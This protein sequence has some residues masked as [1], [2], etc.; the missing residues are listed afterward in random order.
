[1]CMRVCVRACARVC[2]RVCERVCVRLCVRT[3]VCACVCAR[4]CACVCVCVCL[5][6]S[7]ESLCINLQKLDEFTVARILIRTVKSQNSS[8][9][10]QC[11]DRNMLRDSWGGVNGKLSYR[12]HI[13]LSVRD[14]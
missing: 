12:L 2:A 10:L 5:G 7:T 9:S 14:W 1:M 11:D 4:V 3:C 8:C 13:L 6:P